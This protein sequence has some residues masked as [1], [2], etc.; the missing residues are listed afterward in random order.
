MSRIHKNITKELL[1][2]PICGWASKA[3]MPS[4][5]NI[6]YFHFLLGSGLQY[7]KSGTFF[8]FLM[9]VRVDTQLFFFFIVFKDQRHLEMFFKTGLASHKTNVQST[10]ESDCCSK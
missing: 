8:F 9:R 3:L 10:I 5:N 4:A 7:R 2:W 1:Q 6:S